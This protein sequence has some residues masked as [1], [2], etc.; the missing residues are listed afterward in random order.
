MRLVIIPS[1]NKV[2]KDGYAFSNLNLSNIPTDVHAL[3]WEN[4][5]GWI[6]YKKHVKPNKD[7][8]S[9]PQWANDAL[10]IWQQTYDA[11][12]TNNASEEILNVN[13]TMT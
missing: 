1:E 10:N 6:E 11:E 8:T 9:L 7:I 12:Q 2:N 3:Q 5:T 4:D 13:Q